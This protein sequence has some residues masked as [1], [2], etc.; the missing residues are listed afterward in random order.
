MR[1]TLTLDDDVAALLEQEVKRSG[2]P[3]K[4]T[5]NRLLRS[6]LHQAAKPVMPKPFKV[7]ARKIGLPA[8]WTSGSIPEL[9]EMLEG[10]LHK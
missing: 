8:E 5:V 3:M 2:E 1:T 7:K 9:I 10:P 4:Q 6:G